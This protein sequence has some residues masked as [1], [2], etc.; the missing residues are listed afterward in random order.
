[1]TVKCSCVCAHLRKHHTETEGDTEDIHFEPPDSDVPALFQTEEE[2]TIESLRGKH[3]QC[4]QSV[5][6]K[7]R[8]LTDCPY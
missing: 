2:T 8:L 3:S 6:C 7:G 5:C 4:E 1:M